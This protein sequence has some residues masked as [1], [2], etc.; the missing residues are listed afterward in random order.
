MIENI[1]LEIEKINKRLYS[2][3]ID[4]YKERYKSWNW[5]STW[6]LRG[7]ISTHEKIRELLVNGKRV[8]A[9]YYC[10]AVR[11]YHDRFIIWKD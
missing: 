11:G 9:G 2:N 4:Q 10:T 7:I 6:E 1:D 3:R 8:T 5:I